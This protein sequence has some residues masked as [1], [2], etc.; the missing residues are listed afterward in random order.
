MRGK[1]PGTFSRK[2]LMKP[3]AP[4]SLPE[5]APIA[6]CAWQVWVL[7]GGGQ[8]CW[9]AVGGP[10]QESLG[11][12]S[13]GV[14]QCAPQPEKITSH[15]SPLLDKAS[16]VL[17]SGAVPRPFLGLSAWLHALPVPSSSGSCPP[18]PPS[19]IVSLH[20]S[21]SLMRATWAH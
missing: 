3:L 11:L 8:P 4:V 14:G 12:N 6:L 20:L 15:L 9:A 18:H 17:P 5:W 2:W 21:M 10:F 7:G 1:V 13:G 19:H 16:H